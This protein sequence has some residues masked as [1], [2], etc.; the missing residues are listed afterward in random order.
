MQYNGHNNIN[1]PSQ[2]NGADAASASSPVV[3]RVTLASKLTPGEKM[4]MVVRITQD[5]D[6]A[7]D[8]F[9]RGARERL[10]MAPTQRIRIYDASNVEIRSVEDIINGEELIVVPM[11]AREAEISFLQNPAPHPSHH[12][13]YSDSMFV[14]GPHSVGVTTFFNHREQHEDLPQGLK[15]PTNIPAWE[16]EARMVPAEKR[17]TEDMHVHNMNDKAIVNCMQ[18]GGSMGIN[19]WFNRKEQNGDRSQG[20]KRFDGIGESKCLG[21]SLAFEYNEKD[22]Q[23]QHHINR[24]TTDSRNRWKDFDPKRLPHAAPPSSRKSVR[25][26]ASSRSTNSSTIRVPDLPFPQEYLPHE[27]EDYGDVGGVDGGGRSRY[28]NSTRSDGGNRSTNSSQSGN[29]PP[30]AGALSKS[31]SPRGKKQFYRSTPNKSHRKLVPANNRLSETD[32]HKDLFD[33]MKTSVGL[34]LASPPPRGYGS[35]ARRRK[36]KAGKFSNR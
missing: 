11:S 36:V 1:M 14:G 33:P 26:N 9:I 4:R 30:I 6:V 22:V 20:T 3:M 21:N 7:W 2:L 13:V 17:W 25:S 24:L 8:S 18:H 23:R 28:T 15:V 16:K 5:K 12:K 27:V 35:G 31:T 10:G 32:K 19:T 34:L 29:Q